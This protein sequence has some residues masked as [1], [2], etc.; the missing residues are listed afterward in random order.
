LQE[1]VQTFVENTLRRTVPNRAF[2]AA[3]LTLLPAAGPGAATAGL[4]LGAKGSATAKS[5]LA[6]GLL[7]PLVPFLGIAAGVSAHW[8]VIRD[9]TADPALR[10]KRIVQAILAWMIYLGFA[11]GGEWAV[12][13]TVR[14]FGGSDRVNFATLAVFWWLVVAGTFA[15]QLALIR[16]QLDRRREREA[17]TPGPVAVVQP[18]RPLTLGAVAVGAHLAMFCWLIVL[19]WRCADATG[20][21]I[22][23]GVMLV[24]GMA[25]YVRGR[26]Q[27]GVALARRAGIHTGAIGIAILLIL[28]LRTNIW[29]AASY[30]VSVADASHVLP[31][32]IVPVLSLAL[33]V[34]VALVFAVV[35]PGRSLPRR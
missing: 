30:G 24:L 15:V 7:A 9:G 20:A 8:L 32:W 1:E 11:V 16:R 21:A 3:V 26:G 4:G 25:A 33:V 2:S 29:V 10:R 34:W 14:F 23:A 18:V 31:T 22:T 13:G 12:Y 6:A 27:T 35:R 5:G 28:N 17:A 19:A